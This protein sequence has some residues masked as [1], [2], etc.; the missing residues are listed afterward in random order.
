MLV[1]GVLGAIQQH[2]GQAGFRVTG[3]LPLADLP[4]GIHVREAV[5]V[6]QVQHRQ[7]NQ[8]VAFAIGKGFFQQ[9]F[10]FMV[11]GLGAAGLGHQQ[12]TQAR[13]GAGR[14]VRCRTVGGLSLFDLRRIAGAYL[15]VGQAHLGLAVAQVC[16]LLVI[17]LRGDGVATL[18]RFIGQA[19]VGQAGATGE[20]DGQRQGH[21]QVSKG[22]HD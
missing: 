22:A 7:R 19:L 5:R 13:L 15:D 2:L 21:R 11:F 14:G 16:Q 10:G 9:A 4:L 12:A 8:G 3:G 20:G 6:L 1:V 17:L 18:E